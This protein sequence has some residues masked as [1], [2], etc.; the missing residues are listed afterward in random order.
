MSKLE[1]LKEELAEIEDELESLR[2]RRLEIE[3]EFEEFERCEKYEPA[4]IAALNRNYNKWCSKDYLLK[5]FPWDDTDLD[6]D[7]EDSIDK[8]L[9]TCEVLVSKGIIKQKQVGED[10]RGNTIYDYRIT[11]TETIDM[12][13]NTE[14]N[15]E[16]NTYNRTN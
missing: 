10:W 16:R 1:E 4:V 2:E 13:E 7:D 8:V 14:K 15:H 6:R 5:N 12:F 9:M 3:D 11:D